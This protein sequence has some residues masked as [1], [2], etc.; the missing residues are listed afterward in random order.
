MQAPVS[1]PQRPSPADFDSRKTYQ[2]VEAPEGF[3]DPDALEKYRALCR[4]KSDVEGRLIEP[5]LTGNER[6]L[7]IG[8]GNGRNLI[9]LAEKKKLRSALGMDV[10]TSRVAFAREW[11]RDSGLDRIL[12]FRDSD[13]MVEPAAPASFDMIICITA[14]FGYFGALEKGGDARMMEWMAGNLVPGGR[15]VMELYLYPGEIALMRERPGEPLRHWAELPASDPF[16]FYLHER[17]WDGKGG[18]LYHKKL[19]IHR[20]GRVDEGRGDSQRIYRLDEISVLMERSG[21]KVEKACGDWN[22]KPYSLG[23]EILVIQALKPA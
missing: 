12:E 8:C 20:S 2:G 17:W 1:D 5:L 11:A 13:V 22:G 9:R 6:I 7:E 21:L 18:I 16:R 4:G 3:T 19:F 10:A 23:D 14:A 15:L